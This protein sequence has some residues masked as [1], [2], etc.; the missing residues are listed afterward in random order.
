DRH[1]AGGQL[2]AFARLGTLRNLDFELF[3]IH[4]VFGSDSKARRCYLFHP[5]VG[6]AVVSVGS[7]IFSALT[8]VAA[9][10]QAIHGD[11]KSAVS[12][13]RNRAQRHSLRAEP[14]ENRLFGFDII[15][16]K[17]LVRNNFQQV[18]DSNRLSLMAE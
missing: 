16:R 13:G 17:R 5:V 12:L 1:L 11:S 8:S 18:A 4:Q 7:R 2:A 9:S 14:A 6:L 15:E 10:A 3:G